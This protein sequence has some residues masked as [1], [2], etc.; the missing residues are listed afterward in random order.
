MVAEKVSPV[1]ATGAA[2]TAEIAP[3]KTWA[4]VIRHGG[5]DFGV[6]IYVVAGR[7]IDRDVYDLIIKIDR[8]NYTAEEYYGTF[9]AWKMDVDVDGDVARDIVAAVLA[10]ALFSRVSNSET[11]HSDAYYSYYESGDGIYDVF[12]IRADNSVYIVD[13]DGEVYN[14]GTLRDAEEYIPEDFGEEVKE[15]IRRFIRAV[16]ALVP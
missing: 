14:I 11:V 6:T 3:M 5:R 2:P 8:E 15:F 9:D 4:K 16:R 7:Q 12:Y 13:P 10:G 1:G